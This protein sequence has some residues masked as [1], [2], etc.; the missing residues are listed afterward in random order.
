MLKRFTIDNIPKELWI[1]IDRRK[2]AASEIFFQEGDPAQAIYYLES[3]QIRLLNY[4]LSGQAADHYTVMAGE[5]FGEVLV[6]SDQCLCTCIAEEA[7]QVLIIPKQPFLDALR[8]YP[9]L[10]LAFLGEVAYRLHM[11]KI[12]MRLRGIRSARDR[13]LSYLQIVAK[14]KTN[15]VVLDRLLKEIA[16]DLDLTPESLSR[17]LTQLESEKT[18]SRVTGRIILNP[19]IDG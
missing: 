3:G 4:T 6:A 18:I 8:Q 13:V 9:D 7:S 2:L 19:E 11:T 17:A 16:R 12:I 14:P 15:I 10:A 5:F 1:K